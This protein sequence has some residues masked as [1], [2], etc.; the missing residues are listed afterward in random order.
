MTK[1]LK[2]VKF[3]PE[4]ILAF[5]RSQKSLPADAKPEKMG[6]DKETGYVVCLV[7]SET[8][9]EVAGPSGIPEIK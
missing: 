4:M 5:L 7:S 3:T 1:R 9:P 6:F 2:Y 8:F